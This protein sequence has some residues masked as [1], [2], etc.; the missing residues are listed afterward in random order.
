MIGYALVR[1]A[2][3]ELARLSGWSAPDRRLRSRLSIATF[4]RVLT[5]EERAEYPL[6]G[7]AVTPEEL[8]IVCESLARHFTCATLADA[9]ERWL[10]G[11]DPERPL[12][13]IT[14]DDGQIDNLTRAAPV[15]AKHGLRAS[16]F[17]VSSAA[18]SGQSLWHDRMAF[19][20]RRG[21][22]REPAAVRALLSELGELPAG[23]ESQ[24]AELVER[25]KR[26]LTEA[27]PREQW[28]Q[29]L[30]RAAGGAWRPAWDG[31]L[32]WDD[33][34][35]LQEMGHEIGSHSHSHPLLPHCTDDELAHELSHSKRELERETGGPVSSFC[36]PNGDRDGRV[37]AAAEKAGYA[38]AVTTRHGWNSR[39][40]ALHTLRRCDL[41]FVH[42]ADRTGGFSE[43]RLA[44]RLSR[45]P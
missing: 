7:L 3:A 42:C 38:R 39:G 37:I 19:A 44:L 29:R 10:A 5:S 25:V 41:S 16:F 11:E 40:D 1:D 8:D 2:A 14:F 22:A 24:P 30:E 20:L 33:V 4:H 36:Y 6:P 13:A 32:A 27:E 17:V 34:R 18:A 9:S 31:M 23:I 21:W 43:A 12:L 15:L 28:I 45:R 35:A 26:T